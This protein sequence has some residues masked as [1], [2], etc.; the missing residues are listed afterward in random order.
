V[1]RRPGDVISRGKHSP[2]HAHAQAWCRVVA[3]AS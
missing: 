1:F 2:N 3:E